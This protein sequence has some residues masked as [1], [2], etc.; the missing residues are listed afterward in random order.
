MT[1]QLLLA[2]GLSFT[3]LLPSL[4]EQTGPARRG[5][6]AGAATRKLS[7]IAPAAPF[8]S[9]ISIHHISQ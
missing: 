9:N 3:V 1:K 2:L 7:I 5:L 6:A 4:A 8:R